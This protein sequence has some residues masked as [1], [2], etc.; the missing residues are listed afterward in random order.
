MTAG[1]VGY[2]VCVAVIRRRLALDG[3]RRWRWP[4][5]LALHGVCSVGIFLGRILRLNTWDL[6]V[7]PGTVL[8]YVRL[9]QPTT[10]A[11]I[12]FTFCALAAGT[13]ALRVP[14]AIHDQHRSNR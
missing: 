8:G 11:L 2:G 6:L 12:S 7:R 10:V 13:L 1:L 5:E 3:L 4:T 14:A 9:P